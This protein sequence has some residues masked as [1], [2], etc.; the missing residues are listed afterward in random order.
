VRFCVEGGPCVEEG[1]N[2]SNTHDLSCSG[3]CRIR[4]QLLVAGTQTTNQDN[5]K[6]QLLRVDSVNSV[7]NLLVRRGDGYGVVTKPHGYGQDSIFNLHVL[8]PKGSVVADL[9]VHLIQCID[10]NNQGVTSISTEKHIYIENVVET[11]AS[12][13]EFRIRVH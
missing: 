4:Q 13:S 6:Q 11:Y 5:Q 8:L 3:N 12:K 9:D 10:Y 1:F 2:E 7:D